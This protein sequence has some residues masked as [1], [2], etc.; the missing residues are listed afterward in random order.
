MSQQVAGGRDVSVTTDQ[1][2][3]T[4]RVSQPTV[5]GSGPITLAGFLAILSY[6]NTYFSGA[7]IPASNTDARLPMLQITT[8][9]VV[10]NVMSGDGA[11]VQAELVTLLNT[12]GNVAA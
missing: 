11:T 10:M 2:W 1:P 7:A 9:S 5:P 4:V 8:S 6:A 3:C 12:A